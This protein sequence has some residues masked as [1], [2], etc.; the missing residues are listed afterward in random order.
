MMARGS[1]DSGDPGRFGSWEIC[2]GCSTVNCKRSTVWCMYC[3]RS[4]D[5]EI[6]VWGQRCSD[7]TIMIYSTVSASYSK[8]FVLSLP[9][10][11][12]PGCALQSQ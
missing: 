7:H 3:F 1:Q 10:S 11:S 5:Q 4:R 9:S 6:A 8:H 12:S 2:L